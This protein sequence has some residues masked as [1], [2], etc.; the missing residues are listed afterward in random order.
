MQSDA[1]G[2]AQDVPMINLAAIKTFSIYFIC[3]GNH[4]L[5]IS[6]QT[7]LQLIAFPFQTTELTNWNRQASPVQTM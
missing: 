4:Y 1:A 7:G 5:Q 6:H 3:N 2:I